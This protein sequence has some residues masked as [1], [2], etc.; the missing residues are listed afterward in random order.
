[1]TRRGTLVY[2]L[3]AVV[4][5]SF[6][7]AGSYYLYFLAHGASHGHWARDFSFVF[8]LTIIL[9]S[10]ALLVASLLL[11]WLA[12]RLRW[13]R[14]WE[15]VVAG[16]ALFLLTGWAFGRFG[17]FIDRGHDSS[18]WRTGVLF[19]LAGPMFVLKRPIWLLIPAGAA[20]ALVLYKVHS[21]FD[22]SVNVVPK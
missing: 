14:A 13:T 22:P 20:T 18:P 9:S 1:M 17:M 8:F 11:R 21:R 19:L 6:F 10:G 3:A 12:Q 15:W 4:C 16:V 5:G 7:L 2:Y